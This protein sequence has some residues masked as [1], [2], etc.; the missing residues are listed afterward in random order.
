MWVCE[1]TKCTSGLFFVSVVVD[2]VSLSPPA[3]LEEQAKENRTC[4]T[5]PNRCGLSKRW[6][7]RWRFWHHSCKNLSHTHSQLCDKYTAYT[8]FN[9]FIITDCRFQSLSLDFYL[10]SRLRSHRDSCIFSAEFPGSAFAKAKP[11]S[12]WTSLTRKGIVRVVFF[13]FF[14]RWWIQVTSRAI[15]LLLLAL[16]LLQ[17][18]WGVC[19]PSMHFGFHISRIIPIYKMHW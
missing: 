19:S 12:P 9:H 6:E 4:E 11:E 1:G 14:Y 10:S 2:L 17:G 18:V 13:P 15:F 8:L 5:R 3:G 7:Q 16:Y